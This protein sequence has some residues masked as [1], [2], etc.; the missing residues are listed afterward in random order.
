VRQSPRNRNGVVP[1]SLIKE[2]AGP[3]DDVPVSYWFNGKS[4]K[5]FYTVIAV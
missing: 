2:D 3:R 4:Y 1:F 5:Q